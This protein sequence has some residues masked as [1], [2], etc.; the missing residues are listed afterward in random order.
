MAISETKVGLTHHIFAESAAHFCWVA[1]FLLKPDLASFG[2]S[3]PGVSADLASFYWQCIYGESALFAHSSNFSWHCTILAQSTMTHA[4]VWH[5]QWEWT[6]RWL[7]RGLEVT[8]Q[9]TLTLSLSLTLA[10]GHVT[11]N[12]NPRPNPNRNNVG[13]A[14]IT[15]RGLSGEWMMWG[16]A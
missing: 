3:S 4:V 8:W 7:G 16:V 12:P 15:G 9:L 13:V 2:E 5:D 11:S 6:E 1:K 14:A 10:L